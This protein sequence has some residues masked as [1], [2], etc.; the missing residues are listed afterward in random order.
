MLPLIDECNQRVELLRMLEAM[1]GWGFPNLRIVL[2]SR[3]ERDIE[4]SIEGFV[5]PQ[6]KIC[7]ESDLVDGDIQHYVRQRLCDDKS[8]SKWGKDEALRTEVEISLMKGAKGM[9]VS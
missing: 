1:T 2:T 3:Q 8:L 9:Y 7:L 4:I 6:N 5:S